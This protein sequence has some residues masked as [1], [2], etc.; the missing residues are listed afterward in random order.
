MMN[1]S[2]VILCGLILPALSASQFGGKLQPFLGNR[3]PSMKSIASSN[4]VVPIQDTNDVS[5]P[6]E[7]N[8]MDY[9]PTSNDTMYDIY[10]IYSCPSVNSTNL[11]I[12]EWY[13]ICKYQCSYTTPI[14]NMVV[15]IY[16]KN[17]SIGKQN[18][19]VVDSY[20]VT[21][22]CHENIWGSEQ[23]YIVDSKPKDFDYQGILGVKDS[24][25]KVMGSSTS[26]V[27]D[28]C[29][30]PECKYLGDTYNEGVIYKLSLE[31]W[32]LSIDAKHNYYIKGPSVPF[33]SYYS[34]MAMYYEGKWYIWNNDH[35]ESSIDCL[36]TPDFT[37][38]CLYN[39]DSGLI[40][41][42][43]EGIIINAVGA[44]LA[45]GTCVGDVNISSNGLVYQVSDIQN[46]KSVNAKLQ[47][48]Q[49]T[50][51][52]S[53]TDLISTL[54]DTLHTLEETYC[55]SLCDLADRSFQSIIEVEDV[56]DTAN[57]PWLVK[58][59][60]TGLRVHACHVS[61]N[62]TPVLPLK[63]CDDYTLIQV[64]EVNTNQIAWWDPTVTYVDPNRACSD[65]GEETLR[66]ITELNKP[67]TIPFWRGYAIL[68]PPYSG[69]IMWTPRLNPASV[70]SAK[71]F[72]KLKKVADSNPLSLDDIEKSILHHVNVTL[73]QGQQNQTSGTYKLLFDKIVF[74]L[75]Q[76]IGVIAITLAN[77][78]LIFTLASIAIGGCIM[79]YCV[80]LVRGNNKPQEWSYVG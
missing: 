25:F 5:I 27:Y 64:K 58:N 54:Y 70:R 44:Y 22:M 35:K 30:N 43:N 76:V 52:G 37:D 14:D 42:P 46:S 67:I 40:T 28:T 63:F 68:N 59:S 75:Q 66:V 34:D 18:V 31:V 33:A 17:S 19:I 15:T 39:Q 24:L 41:C 20:S 1:P 57:G 26:Y 69:P 55:G 62:Y 32:D 71:W 9:A 45:A 21:K 6:S 72:P 60:S 29:G 11:S 36:F 77:A 16:R 51:Q 56:V 50:S 8:L 10:P 38:T 53:V 48:I 7:V 80:S 3:I 61:T 65:N 79:W 78:P 47:D 13:G 4:V 2:Y 49:S 12:S 73:G 74:D 23:T